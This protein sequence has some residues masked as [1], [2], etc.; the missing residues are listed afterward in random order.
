MA[1]GQ[2]ARIHA[3]VTRVIGSVERDL[4]GLAHTLPASAVGAFSCAAFLREQE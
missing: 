1:H 3:P 2:E 4:V